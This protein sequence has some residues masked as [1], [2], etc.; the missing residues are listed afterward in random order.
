[1]KELDYTKLLITGQ[2]YEL[3]RFAPLLVAIGLV[4]K[5]HLER[6]IVFKSTIF[7]PKSIKVIAAHSGVVTAARTAPKVAIRNSGVQ[8]P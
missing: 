3:N 2:K 4:H 7:S 1:M 5:F 8:L 6:V